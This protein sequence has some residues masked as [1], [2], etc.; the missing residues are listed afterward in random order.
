MGTPNP[1]GI[2]REGM[3]A[4]GGGKGENGWTCVAVLE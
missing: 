2:H 3:D 4:V 1:S